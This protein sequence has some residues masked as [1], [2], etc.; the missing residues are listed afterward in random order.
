MKMLNDLHGYVFALRSKI[1]KAPPTCESSFKSRSA[2]QRLRVRLR[3]G[4]EGSSLAEFAMILPILCMFLT[5]IFS[6]GAAFT[7]K[8]AITQAVGI[9]AQQLAES[10]STSADP[11][12][13]TLT[14]IQNAA[15]MLVVNSKNPSG[16]VLTLT[17]NGITPSGNPTSCSSDASDLQKLQPGSVTVTA[18]YACPIGVYGLS[19]I[20]ANCTATV[21]ESEP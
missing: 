3:L 10:R 9:G 15:P 8:Q 17:M 16:I 20:S 6:I 4:E 7:Q 18:S 11:C 1:R 5:G 21:T 13:E 14:A 2:G 19:L 12:A